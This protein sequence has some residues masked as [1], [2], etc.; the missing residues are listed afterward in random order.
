MEGA[1]DSSRGN[2]VTFYSYKGGTG[3]TMALANTACVLTEFERAHGG[4]VLLVDWDLE[5]PGLHRFFPPRLRTLDAAPG[6]G[7]D[8]QLG[9][10]DLMIELRDHLPAEPP[11]SAE[12]AA[13]AATAALDAVRLERYIAPTEVH[14]VTLM[15]AGRDDD[16][17]YGKRV[18]TF[19][20]EGLFVRAPT[21]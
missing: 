11:A 2:V 10:I 5:A 17:S 16:G 18:A 1:P 20:W 19:D 15:R 6:L 21:I 4:A 12:A 7:L 14:G 8:D 13:E 9:L 3:R